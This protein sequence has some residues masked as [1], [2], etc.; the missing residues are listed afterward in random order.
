MWLVGAFL[1]SAGGAAV[2]AHQILRGSYRPNLVSRFVWSAATC[3]GAA[4][5]FADGGLADGAA[6]AVLAA[7][8]V[9]VT[10]AA[11]TRE[12]VLRFDRLEVACGLLAAA[13]VVGWVVTGQP[14]VAAALA[15]AADGIGAVPTLRQVWRAPWREDP[16][17][18]IG[19]LGAALCVLAAL[20]THTFETAA[21]SAYLVI[22]C[23]FVIVAVPLR[24]RRIA[25]PDDEGVGGGAGQV[26]ALA[27]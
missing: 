12:P 6:V 11:L 4:V 13:G 19:G 26:E 15:V 5:A 16:A 18:Y 23:G 7:G 27:A 10:I 22:L 1:F 3:I 14:L 8:S 25:R 2:A 17:N 9:A 21:F 24:R 20:D